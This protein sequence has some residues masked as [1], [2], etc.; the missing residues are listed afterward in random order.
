MELL[1]SKSQNRSLVDSITSIPYDVMVSDFDQSAAWMLRALSLANDIEYTRG[2]ADASAKLSTITYLQGQYDS[3]VFYNLKAIAL[4]DSLGKEV[5]MGEMFCELGYQMKRRDLQR[6]FGYFRQGLAYLEKY[7]AVEKLCAAYDNFGVLHEMN[8][9]LDSAEFFYTKALQFKT[10][11]QDSIG[12]PFSLNNLGLLQIIRGNYDSA[13]HFFEEAYRIRSLR[14]DAFGIAENKAY[15][16][17][18]YKAWQNWNESI[19]WYELSNADCLALKYPRQMQYNFEQLA[20]CLEKSGRLSEAIAALQKSI[21]I[22]DELMNEE[23]SRTMLELEEKYKSAEKDRNIAVLGAKSASRKLWI[24]GIAGMLLFVVIVSLWYTNIQRRNAEAARVAA[25]I[26]EREAGLKAL[27]EATEAERK[28]IARDLHDGIGQQLSGLRMS[29]ESLGLK[30][31]GTAVIEHQ[32]ISKLTDVLDGACSELR[33]ISHTMMPRALQEKGLVIAMGELLEK[34]I[35]ITKIKYTFEHFSVDK[36]RWN[37]SIELSIFRVFQ[38]LLNNVLKHS[39]ATEIAVQFYK[40][41]KQLIL[42]VEDNGVGM[43]DQSDIGGIGKLNIVTR[44]HTMNGD[45]MWNAGPERG[46][47]VTVRMPVA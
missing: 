46:T 3:S 41:G 44:L 19:K 37:E 30:I 7:N 39:A 34:T 15:F 31:A 5:Q 1:H 28:R 26:A 29:W 27:F 6:A 45:V 33:T 23:N 47:V 4:Y 20:F 16:G 12:I 18:L 13:E 42:I 9:E 40:N 32:Q 10:D 43:K 25:I 8:N 21:K 17:D 14:H 38:E 11:L 22:K 2:I 24:Y 36:E 35:G